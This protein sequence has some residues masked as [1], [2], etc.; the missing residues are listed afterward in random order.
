MR[1][2]IEWMR[3]CKVITFPEVR[4]FNSHS[5]ALRHVGRNRNLPT[6]LTHVIYRLKEHCVYWQRITARESKTV[7]PGKGATIA[8]GVVDRATR[9]ATFPFHYVTGRGDGRRRRGV[10]KRVLFNAL[11]VSKQSCAW[12]RTVRVRID[13]R[14]HSVRFYGLLQIITLEIDT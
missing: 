7:R 13:H 4:Y 9:L 10:C 8:S 1:S 14:V 5:Y 6:T 11:H 12:S 3:C 2:G